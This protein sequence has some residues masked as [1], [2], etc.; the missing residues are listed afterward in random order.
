MNVQE[1]TCPHCGQTIVCTLD[2]VGT[3][4]TC[5]QCHHLVT[6]PPPGDTED[7]AAWSGLLPPNPREEPQ[8]GV[9]ES[10]VGSPAPIVARAARRD[11]P[12]LVLLFLGP[13]AL[14]TSGIVGFFFWKGREQQHPLEWLVDQQPADGGPKLPKNDFPLLDRQKTKLG[15]PIRVGDVC[16]VMPIDVALL[17]LGEQAV[18]KLKVRNISKDLRFNPLPQSFMVPRG[19]SFLEFGNQRVYGGKLTWTKPG[20]APFNGVLGP[21]EEM[22]VNLTTPVKGAETLRKLGEHRGNVLWRLE[23]RRGIVEVHGK[24]VS[25]TAVIGIEFNVGALLGD[26]REA[27]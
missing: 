18:L 1:F 16:E 2:D 17:P 12:M 6:V 8:P 25:A 24:P 23:V 3:M 26:Q 15:E 7:A 13:Y 21:G 4:V 20:S 14:V 11:W 5:P 9:F 10:A 19:F 22:T 27:A